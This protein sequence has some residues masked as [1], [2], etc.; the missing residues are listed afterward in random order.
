VINGQALCPPCNLA[1]GDRVSGLRQWQQRAID[2]Y[3]ARG[4]QDFLL[5]ATPGAG[6]TRVS[7]AIARRLLDDGTIERVAVVVPTDPLRLQWCDASTDLH[8][9]PLDDGIVSKAGYDG[10]VLTYAQLAVGASADLMRR[11]VS[12]HKTLGIFDEAHHSGAERA[13]ARGV[14]TAFG[15]AARRLSTTGTPWRRDNRE[16][17][18]VHYGDDGLVSVDYHYRYA[19]AVNDRICR[20]IVFHA[21]NGEARW[22]DCGTIIEAHV[23]ED[24]DEDQTGAALDTLYRPEHQWMPAMLA[25]AARALD[26]QRAE[27]V[28]DAGGLVLA[29]TRWHA[30]EYARLLEEITGEKPVLIRGDDPLAKDKIDSFRNGGQR[31]IISVRMISEGID[32][33]R[34]AIGVYA[35]KKWTPL[36]FRQAV[37]RLVR[38]RGDENHNAQ[39]FIP[40]VPAIVRHAYEIEQEL[41]HELAEEEEHAERVRKEAEERQQTLDLRMPLSAS[42]PIFTQAIHRGLGYEPEDLTEAVAKCQ[43]FGIP[44]DKAVNVARLLQ[45]ERARPL[46]VSAQV[47]VQ[48]AAAAE[49]Q[50]RLERRLRQEVEALS[51]RLDY[52]EDRDPGSTNTALLRAGFPRRKTASIEELRRMQAWLAERLS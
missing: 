17:P 35:A 1:K 34:L 2:E 27:D 30:L 52:M 23:C 47:T 8:L 21:H 10:V 43:Q 7:L 31:W 9:R 6:K 3:L 46:D 26:L 48:P 32:I 14:L 42:E 37:G 20:P 49:S 15:T 41:L 45:E 18:F 40:A 19:A 5:E 22:V 51:R 25:K 33:P 24:L 39:M 13:Y 29:E 4:Q 28:P 11:D 38:Q 12:R 44:A 50:H 36:F 16:I